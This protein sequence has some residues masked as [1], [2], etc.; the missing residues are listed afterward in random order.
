MIPGKWKVKS[1]RCWKVQKDW[2][3]EWQDIRV[4][5]KESEVFFSRINSQNTKSWQMHVYEPI[6]ISF[7]LLTLAL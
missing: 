2:D 6:P 1:W 4:T 7:F 3:A 5:A